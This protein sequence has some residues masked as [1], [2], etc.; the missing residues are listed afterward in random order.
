MGGSKK[1]REAKTSLSYLLEGFDSA[2]KQRPK[3]TGSL[4]N[5]K[6]HTPAEHDL[7]FPKHIMVAGLMML[8]PRSNHPKSLGEVVACSLNRV[9]HRIT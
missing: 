7:S 9:S 6:G 8:A 1:H 3:D 2:N 4:G 5:D